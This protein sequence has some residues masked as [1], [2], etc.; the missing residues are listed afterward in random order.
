MMKLHTMSSELVP[1]LGRKD[2]KEILI[3]E[4]F[5]SVRVHVQKFKA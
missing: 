1:W 4:L 2:S 3:D 5:G